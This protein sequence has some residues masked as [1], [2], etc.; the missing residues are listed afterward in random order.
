MKTLFYTTHIL[1]K[2]VRKVEI[3]S[4][5][6]ITTEILFSLISFSLFSMKVRHTIIYIHPA[7]ALVLVTWQDL[8][9]VN[10]Q[11]AFPEFPLLRKSLCLSPWLITFAYNK[12]LL[13]GVT[14]HIQVTFYTLRLC[15]LWSDLFNQS[16]IWNEI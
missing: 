5:N 9:I 16:C 3:P 12:N 6:V 8:E 13:A 15:L 1:Q 10:I 7:Q 11:K 4:N 14:S 2:D